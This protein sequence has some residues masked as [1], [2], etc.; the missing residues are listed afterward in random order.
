MTEQETHDKISDVHKAISEFRKV[1]QEM[2]ESRIVRLAN[3]K[4]KVE[5]QL[6][7]VI[8]NLLSC[9]D[10]LKLTIEFGTVP[11]SKLGRAQ[12]IISYATR[13]ERRNKHT[14]EV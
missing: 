10:I 11:Q 5:E 2:P 4:T 14:P 9:T 12:E 3:E 7:E 1:L 8:H 13:F 6:E